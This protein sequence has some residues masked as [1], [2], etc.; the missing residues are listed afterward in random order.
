MKNIESYPPLKA[1]EVANKKLPEIW[2]A[3]EKTR[4]D[5]LS[6]SSPLW[7]EDIYIPAWQVYEETF[8]YG[9][10][11]VP[12]EARPRAL[13]V[14]LSILASWRRYKEVYRFAPE[15]EELLYKQVD[16]DLLVD[17]LR[18]LPYP[19]FYVETPKILDDRYHGF[20]I[21]YDQ[22]KDGTPLLRCMATK[23]EDTLDFVFSEIRLEKGLMLKDGIAK[24]AIKAAAEMG[25]EHLSEQFAAEMI[26]YVKYWT[27]I[28]SRLCQLLLYLTAQNVDLEEI[29]GKSG[30]GHERVSGTPIKDKYRE[31][32]TWEVGV[33]TVKKLERARNNFNQPNDDAGRHLEG[34]KRIS[35]KP[36]WRGSHWHLF[37]IGKR[38]SEN[39]KFI[40]KWIAPTLINCKTTEDLSMTIN[41]IE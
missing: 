31:I 13:A 6:T 36:H 8:L 1:V 28:L 25:V 14:A 5:M 16:F 7:R 32:R 15:M 2:A 4:T 27:I 29:A 35:P 10:Y 3:I 21:A 23:K 12:A 17:T 34:Q 41:Q 11:N 22:I 38:K 26:I 19:C 20:F 33:R 39:R 18:H 9:P 40:I 24:A 30:R 37:W